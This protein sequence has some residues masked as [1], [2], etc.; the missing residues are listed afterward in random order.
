MCAWCLL[1]CA[2]TQAAPPTEHWLQ[3]YGLQNW[4]AFFDQDGDGFS[5]EEEF[6]WGT[7]PLAAASLPYEFATVSNQVVLRISG[8]PE[9]LSFLQTTTD[10]LSWQPVTNLPPAT[11]WMVT[12]PATDPQRFFSIGTLVH[13][14][15]DGDCLLDF[16][17]LVIFGTNPYLTDTDSDGLDD[18]AEVKVYHTNPNYLSPTG[19]GAISGKVVLDEDADPATQSHSGL[20]DWKVFL[21]LDYDGQP[22]AFE[23]STQTAADGS[24]LI[25]ELD[26]GRYRVRVE[27]RPGWAQ[28]FPTTSPPASPDGYTD[29]VVDVFDSGTGPIPFPYG[30]LADPLP[31]DR[32][33]L[34]GTPAPVPAETVIGPLP[35]PPLVAPI[36]TWAHADWL[37]MPS[38]ST[39]TVAFDGEEVIDGPGD[40]LW[41]FT[42]LQQGSLEQAEVYLGSTESNLTYATTI[43]AASPNALDLAL[44]AVPQPVRF[45]K[46]RSLTSIGYFP[47]LEI[48]GFQAV[49]Y[50]PAPTGHY[51]VEVFGSQTVSNVNFGVIGDDRPP[52]VFVSL[53]DDNLRAGVAAQIIVTVSD[54]VGI[55]N[56]TLHA[57]SAV[58]TLDAGRQGTFTPSSGGLLEFFATATD[59]AGQTT[60]TLLSQVVRNAD[61]SLPDLSGYAI[62]GSSAGGPAINV[63]SP[64]A[65]EILVS[66]HDLIGTISGT[67]SPVASWSVHYALAELVNPEALADNDPDYV[68]LNQGAGPVTSASL[69]TLAGDTLPAGAYLVRVS[70]TDL[71]S[72]TAYLGFVLGV[73]VDPLD[74]RP[75][76]VLTQPTNET[77]I[78]FVTNVIGSV[79]TRQQLREWYVEYAPL[80]EVNLQNLSD[81][82]PSWTRIAAGTN[83]VT[84]AVLATFDPT[85]LPNDSYVI[86]V[87]A[88]NQ[89]GLGWAESVVLH[90]AGEAKLGNFAVEF[91]DVNIPLAGI[92]ITIRRSYDSLTAARLG[93]FGYGWSL[94][95]QDADIAETV[96]QQGSGLVSTPFKVG[97]RV[98]LTAPDGKR[99]G[100]TF[101]P[102]VG[103]VSFLGA[104]YAATFQPDPGIHYTL[105]VPEGDTAFLSINPAGEAALFFIPLPWNPDTYILTD[106]AGTS[107]T[108]EQSDGLIEIK[109]AN[110]NRVTFTETAIEHS[111]GPRV[112]LGR[113][114][115]GR[116]TQITA[117]DGRIWNYRMTPM[118]TSRR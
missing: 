21:D 27:T 4:Q 86:R 74:I 44:F 114:A 2:R 64:V 101:E 92:P 110:G 23:P 68:L 9:V 45:I 81:N 53:E 36:G 13:T 54:D 58:V 89:N 41:L 112:L 111:G 57:N 117:P 30:R 106:N 35:A 98:Y 66:P 100:F 77:T 46:L 62:S 14:N 87:S 47:G 75:D 3:W 25:A 71:N 80:S 65:G 18:C 56:V 52:H 85:I 6:N 28:V 19:R 76:V 59:T 43:T 69:G 95:V 115:A 38:N 73:R 20:A 118:A 105:S 11:N 42:S 1:V 90:V 88:W 116:I 107:Y 51:D 16:E 15:S 104:A 84:N 50:R 60:D 94:A 10:F 40:D 37:S 67:V 83:S 103:A 61:G 34:G 78:T 5:A 8:T 29:R 32:I 70:A 48:V 33:I 79:T 12:L 63:V 113:D 102:E 24:Y 82:T 55:S 39:I 17:E 31:G 91:T 108:Y 93:D 7:D 99:I 49:N 96:P 72:T 97:A 109:D 22:G 26:P